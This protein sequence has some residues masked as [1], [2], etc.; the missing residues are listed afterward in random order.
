MK[1]MKLY[2]QNHTAYFIR[3]S[4]V[5]PH[6]KTA[7]FSLFFFFFSFILPSF[8]KVSAAFPETLISLNGRLMINR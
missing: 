2:R 4:S 1:L 8:V 6:Y 7:E 3:A 5:V